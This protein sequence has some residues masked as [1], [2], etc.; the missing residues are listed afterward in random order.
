M[1]LRVHNRYAVL[2][3]GLAGLTLI[4]LLLLTETAA[5]DNGNPLILG[6]VN[7]ATNQTVL[8]GELYV[9]PQP[10]QM[11]IVA[12]GAGG[13]AATGTTAAAVSASNHSGPHG[14][15]IFADVTS[16]YAL[17]GQ[18]TDPSGWALR[19]NGRAWF[20]NAGLITISYP[21]KTAQVSGLALTPSSIALATL[22]NSVGVHVTAAIP[23]V[24]S[25][26]VTI[27]LS[28]VPPSGKP[29]IVGWFVID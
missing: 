13:L 2:I 5:G 8:N 29:A 10:N 28:R 9:Q 18:A 16:G 12:N 19:A 22:Q 20:K 24:S 1:N 21:N 6:T 25:G 15:A 14:Y 23:N 26:T 3:A 7:S 11:A 17:A 4:L 27:M